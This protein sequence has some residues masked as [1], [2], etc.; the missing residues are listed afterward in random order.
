MADRPSSPERDAR[1]DRGPTAGAPRWVK[2]SGITAL[3]L[4]LLLL[5]ILLLAGGDHG[6]GR[7]LSARGLGGPLLSVAVASHDWR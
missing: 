6:P 7:H 4:I 2:V 5:L 3:A 1:A